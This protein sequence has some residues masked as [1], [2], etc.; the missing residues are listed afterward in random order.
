[1][2]IIHADFKKGQLKLKIDSPDDLWHLSQLLHH[3]DFVKGKSYRK[4]KLGGTEEKSTVVKKP[5]TIKIKTEKIEF[6]KNQHSLRIN[7]TVLEAPEDIPHG[8]YHTL[9]VELNTILEIEKDHLYDY[10]LRHLQEASKEAH[11]K[12]LLC[13]LERE[14]AH[15]ALL[16]KYG[17]E[18]LGEV[19]GVV[20]N[21]YT[22]DTARKDFY[23][24]VVKILE[25][26]VERMGI[27]QIV[28]G[29]PA[30]WKD[31]IYKKLPAGLRQ[32]TILATCHGIGDNGFNELLRRE[33][34][35][36]ALHQERVHHE[37]ELVE[38]LLKAIAK[39]E[40]CSYGFYEVQEAAKSGA[41]QTLL[42]TDTYLRKKTHEENNKELQ[43]TIKTVEHMKGDVKII[44][45]DHSGGEKLDG[46]GGIAALLR[47]RIKEI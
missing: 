36:T 2:H 41:I 33:E 10:Q 37:L 38:K 23:E 20:E 43:E 35:K 46:L 1:M 32:K 3:G 27:Q 24:E 22:K 17:Y 42:V 19:K 21:K 30:F 29:S 28:I 15:F 26:Y 4:I 5:V 13:T 31:E 11:S 47:Y 8:S 34:V 7:G 45:S 16:R 40:P 12:I 9:N 44:S 14:E 18:N 25:G 6:D 39:N